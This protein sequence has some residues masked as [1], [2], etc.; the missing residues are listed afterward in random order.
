MV[1]IS[2]NTNHSQC[3]PYHTIPYVIPFAMEDDGRLGAHALALLR[4]LAKG[5]GERPTTTLCLSLPCALGSYFGL[6][7]GSAKATTHFHAS[8]FKMAF[9]S[10]FSRVGNEL[11][12]SG[13]GKWGLEDFGGLGAFLHK[14]EREC[15]KFVGCDV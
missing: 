15:L 10:P 14:N 1:L 7:L 11:W 3:I 4:A 6:I 9:S 2:V 5:P 13:H 8:D 12:E